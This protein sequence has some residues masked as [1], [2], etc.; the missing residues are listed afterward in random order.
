MRA[1][2]LFWTGFCRCSVRIAITT[3]QR[4]HHR[5]ALHRLP[6]IGAQQ[7]APQARVERVAHLNHG[8]SCLASEASGVA[9]DVNAQRP[10]SGLTSSPAAF[11]AAISCRSSK[12]HSLNIS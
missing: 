11:A 4:F 10:N 2:G 1:S 7:A 9:I 12:P 3:W 6:G 8:H 5:R